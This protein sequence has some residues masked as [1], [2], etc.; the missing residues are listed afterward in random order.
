MKSRFIKAIWMGLIIGFAGLVLSLVPPGPEL[1]KETGLDILFQLRGKKMPPPDAVVVS[2]DKE[3]AEIMNVPENPDKWPRSLHARLVENLVREGAR[4]ITFDVHFIEPRVIA[5]DRMLAGAID[6]AGNVI[7]CEPCRAKEITAA[8]TKS[9][10]GNAY[11]LIQ[12]VKPI[13]P[14]TE[15]AAATA[16]FV[17]PRIP[18]KVSHYWTFQTGLGDTP[19]MPVL[20]FYLYNMPVCEKFL[21]LMEKI[22]PGRTPAGTRAGQGFVGLE[23]PK[24]TLMRIHE[25]FVQD[26]L[27]ADKMV[28]DLEGSAS[29]CSRQERRRILTL[30]RMFQGSST[31]ILNYYGPPRTITT[32]PFHQAL[33]LQEGRVD[34]RMVDLRG[35]A[36]FVGLSEVL[37]AERKDSFYTVFSEADGLFVS[38]V[39]IMATAFS[40]LLEDQPVRPVGLPAFVAILLAWGLLAGFL[41]RFFTMTWAAA[42]LAG[43][44]LVY[45]FLSVHLFKT[46]NAW[47]PL[48]VPLFFQGPLAFFGGLGWNYVEARK[49]K[50]N[51]KKALEFYV[52]K[53]VVDQLS[54]N[55][56]HIQT[57]GQVVF[58]ICL[59]TDAKNYTTLSETMDPA[60]LGKF[61]NRYYETI[62]RPVKEQEGFVSGVI[63]DAMLALW[64]TP[65]CDNQLPVKACRAGLGIHEAL[66]RFSE[67]SGGINLKTRIG[68]H[69]GQILLGHVG[70]LDHYEYTPMGDIVNTASRI[71]SLNKHLG[72]TLLVSGELIRELTGFVTRDLGTFKLKGKLKPI[73][74]HELVGRAGESNGKKA[75]AFQVFSE[76]MEHFWNQA[77]AAAE[78]KF[79]WVDR[80]LEGDGPARFFINRCRQYQD[81]PPDPSW[82]RVVHMEKK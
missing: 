75:E 16:P 14:L 49:E 67:D 79:N 50:E 43:L 71:E 35:R 10:N 30:I 34:G 27:L 45:L 7:L 81:R 11:S 80:E 70:A 20:V 68:L 24:E 36:V 72:T 4:V 12:V 5:D 29:G 38:G 8:G 41:G 32:L 69:C 48:A 28:S 9:V 3:S 22:D 82:D 47:L 60:A 13:P 37:L 46:Y 31:R 66:R 1:E 52:P 53:D 21:R 62:F 61:M 55:F 54:K 2:I 76:G 6:R 17:L 58:G 78:E 15:A 74:V 77:W 65:T 18:F 44:S 73:A 57:E 59:F 51:I 23:N 40:N 63:G 56:G 25:R 26:P 19:T 64:V 39:E 42:S 33:R